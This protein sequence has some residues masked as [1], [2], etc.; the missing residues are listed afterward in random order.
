M[1]ILVTGGAGFIGSHTVKALLERGDE[2]VIVD[3]LNDYYDVNLKKARL[4]QLTAPVYQ[5]DI[6]NKEAL[7]Q[8]FKEHSFDAI[9]HLAAQAGVRY[10]LENPM[11]YEQ[12]NNVGTLNLLE[13]ARHNNIKPFIYASSSSVYGG[14]TKMPFSEEDP[15]NNPISLYAATKRYN[16]LMAYTYHHLY[17]LHCTGLRFFTVYGEFGRPDMALFLFTK[18]ISKGSPIKL[19]NQGKMK[20]D[21]TYVSDIVEGILASI[22]KQYPY[23]LFNL[24]GDNPVELTYFVD[25]IEKEL[26][27]KAIKELLPIQPGDVPMT[28]ADVSKA[29]RML[30]YAPKVS[31]EEGIKRFVKW[32]VDYFA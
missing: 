21:F 31:I 10:S 7:D 11:A 13:C 2:V 23:E 25:L 16:E 30:G 18:A 12:S 3:N 24:G 8:V 15:V 5:I 4:K 9:V 17:G 14:N 32:Y 27:K 6:S 28:V 1:K 29:R 19:F 20:R 22:D 26:G